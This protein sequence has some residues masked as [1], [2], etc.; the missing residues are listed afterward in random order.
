MYFEHGDRESPPSS[1]ERTI[2]GW[3]AKWREADWPYPC[4][5]LTRRQ[6]RYL[7]G[8]E[9]V[10]DGG[11]LLESG[12]FGRQPQLSRRHEELMWNVLNECLAF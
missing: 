9:I 4:L 6:N 11:W 10:I 3:L 8:A 12:E 1:A 5:F 7:T 2:V